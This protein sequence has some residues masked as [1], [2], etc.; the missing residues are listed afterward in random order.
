MQAVGFG[1]GA[2]HDEGFRDLARFDLALSEATGDK[3]G[4]LRQRF[5]LVPRE[6][7]TET[8]SDFLT[9]QQRVA[10]KWRHYFPAYERH[11]G[12]FV[13]TDVVLIKIGC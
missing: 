13:N 8:W 5:N 7:L 2:Q 11:F 10:D 9:N 6:S 3:P 4:A 12:K 1:I